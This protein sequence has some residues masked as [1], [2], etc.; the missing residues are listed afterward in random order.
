MKR[1][2]VWPPGESEAVL[3]LAVRCTQHGV[4]CAYARRTAPGLSDAH[5][6]DIPL[7]D[8]SLGATPVACAATSLRLTLLSSLL[9]LEQTR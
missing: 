5:E 7:A 2:T 9:L 1:R 8:V 4:G 6:D 3:P